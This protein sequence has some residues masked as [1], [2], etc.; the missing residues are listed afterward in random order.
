M[1][2]YTL[3]SSAFRADS[4]SQ[5]V[6]AEQPLTHVYYQNV[7]FDLCDDYNPMDSI[8]VPRC[9]GVYLII[10]SAFFASATAVDYRTL[11]AIRVN[12]VLVDEQ[13]AFWGESQAGARSSVVRLSSILHLEAGDVVDVV[14]TSTVDGLIWDGNFQAARFPSMRCGLNSPMVKVDKSDA[15]ARL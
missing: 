11:I 10:A 2:T 8:F 15:T 13:N 6:T 7:V 1:K 4:A 14:F 12:D 9:Q 3:R 5:V